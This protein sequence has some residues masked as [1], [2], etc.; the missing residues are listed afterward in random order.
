MADLNLAIVIW[1]RE[2]NQ[3]QLSKGDQ[4]KNCK[5]W[6]S[7]SVSLAKI[8]LFTGSESEGTWRKTEVFGNC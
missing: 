1:N 8:L 4:R 2:L 5:W 6:N 7:M 3:M